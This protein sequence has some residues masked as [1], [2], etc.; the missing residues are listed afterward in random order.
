MEKIKGYKGFDKNMKCRN[1]QY[2]SGKN[3]QHDGKISC[4]HSGFHFCTNPFDVLAYYA[5]ANSRFCEVEGNGESDK[6]GNDTKVSVPNLHV[7]LEI[8]LNGLI[9]AGVKFILNKVKW[10]NCEATNT[11]DYSAAT[12][13]GDYSAATNTG[14][15]S[16]AT[17]TG[18]RSA[19][20][21]TGN[22]SA[23]TN[24]GDRSAATNTGNRSA[25]TNTGYCSAATNTGYYSAATNT[26]DCSAATNT[27]YYSAATNTGDYSAATNTGDCSAATNT[28]NR[29]T[30]TNTGDCSTA[31]NTG[32]RS[33]A[34]NT[35]DC[36][37]ANVEG[38]D[39]IA[40]V[41]GRKSKAAGALG[42]WLVLTERDDNTNIINV[43]AIKVD[44]KKIKA[45]IFYTL[46]D[47]EIKEAEQQ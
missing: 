3:Y 31:T 39:S 41:T 15:C 21:N 2:E 45:N 16:A 28:G 40:I 29:S 9:N 18:N 4:C 12:N 44:G 11:D 22:R 5:P 19:A 7:G 35:G 24:T 46:E 14:D 26:G 43:K 37:T 23:A 38:K 8:G 27:G 32:N 20:T 1:F 10:N 36:S 25:A 42:C 47:G 13:T 34:T 30:A 17:N 6:D 33:T